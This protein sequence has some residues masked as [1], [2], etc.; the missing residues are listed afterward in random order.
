MRV[1]HVNSLKTGGAYKA[2]IRISQATIEQ[3]VESVF[4]TLDD[5][6]SSKIKH[7]LYIIKYIFYRAFSYNT[8]EIRSFYFNDIMSTDII[9][10]PTIKE[11]DII[12]LH[13]VSKGLLGFSSLEKL[14]GTKK[15]IV[16]TVHD[17]H[18]FTGGCHYSEGCEKYKAGCGECPICRRTGIKDFTDYNIKKKK[19]LYKDAQITWVGCSKW[20]T[21][22]VNNSFAIVD[23]RCVT[24]NNCISALS[25][26]PVEKNEARKRL[27]IDRDHYIIGFGAMNAMSDRRKGYDMLVQA[28]QYVKEKVKVKVLLF[29]MDVSCVDNQHI[30]DCICVGEIE[31]EN[32]LRD[33][34]S[35]MDVFVAP[36]RQENFANTVLEAEA[37]GV[38]VV[39][40]DVG[41]MRDLIIHK[42]TGYIANPFDI[43]DFAEGIEYC[44]NNHI[45]MSMNARD[46]IAKRFNY[47]RI[48]E[49]YYRIYKEVLSL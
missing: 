40:F 12:H 23:N 15:P 32:R 25:F 43:E 42:S 46:F 47:D 49:Q 27:G 3:G 22:C 10:H 28:M 31:D 37:C 35:S 34:Y 13:W 24:I 1:V 29:G 45:D 26:Y 30:N 21:K 18:P 44:I 14:I 9:N 11:A 4:F 19:E 36:S 48:G 7:L 17:M 2:A 8:K 5:V 39:A 6:F 33:T 38:P 41:G 16:W 20:I